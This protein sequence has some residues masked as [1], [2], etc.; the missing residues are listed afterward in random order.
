MIWYYWVLLVFAALGLGYIIGGRHESS[1]WV[2]HESDRSCVH[3]KGK[4]YR[5]LTEGRAI[6]LESIEIAFNNRLEEGSYHG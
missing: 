3:H 2:D 5:V 6:Q 4:F 1:Y